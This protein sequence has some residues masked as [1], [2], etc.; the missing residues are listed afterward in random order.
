LRYVNDIR[1]TLAR[2]AVDEL[3]DLLDG[4]VG[5]DRAKMRERIE[6]NVDSGES[7]PFRRRLD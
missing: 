3:G 1:G 7:I 4:T 2:S 5:R 6:Q